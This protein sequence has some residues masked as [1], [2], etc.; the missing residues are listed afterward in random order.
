[1]IIFILT[2]N[3]VSIYVKKIA[4]LISNKFDQFFSDF[5][6][7]V[8]KNY[9]IKRCTDGSQKIRLKAKK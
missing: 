7:S 2:V 6:S 1:V 4:H 9:A 3:N 5:G 8:L